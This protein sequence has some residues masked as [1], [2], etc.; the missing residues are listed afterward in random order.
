MKAALSAAPGLLVAWLLAPANEEPHHHAP[1][2]ETV[3]V[4]LEEVRRAQEGVRERFALAVEKAG[5]LALD[6][7]F[8]SGLPAC[9][10]RARRSVPARVPRELVGK[11]VVFGPADRLPRADVRVATRARK[12][13]ELDADAVADPELVARLGVRCTPTRVEVRSETLL[14]LVEDP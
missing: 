10:A 8:E 13:S 14:E 11:S 2:G 4:S 5:P 6:A 3:P 1:L 7:P 9:A 12:L